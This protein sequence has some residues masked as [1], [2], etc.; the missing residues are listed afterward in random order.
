MS[1]DWEQELATFLTELVAVQGRVLD[2]LRRKRTCLANADAEGL[3]A[4]VPEGEMIQREL[5]SCLEK[6]SKLL[7]KAEKAGVP[8]DSIRSL[9][10][11]TGCSGKLSRRISEANHNM[12]LLQIHTITNWMLS[13]RA[14]I[15]LSRLIEI[16]ATGGQ[17]A[18]TYQE[19]GGPTCEAPQGTLLDQSV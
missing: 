15:H 4:L 19:K 9:A 10:A 5:Q 14:L 6:R 16:I 12:R 1:T 3:A 18:P 2:F 8:A 11:I 17:P 13:Q 7:E